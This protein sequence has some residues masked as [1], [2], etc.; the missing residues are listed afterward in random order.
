M[1]ARFQRLVAV[2]ACAG[3]LWPATAG[4]ASK[5]TAGVRV[6][7]MAVTRAVFATVP[8]GRDG[9]PQYIA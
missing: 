9:K 6:A 3:G 7:T 8:P 4:A 2:L 5:V 1:G